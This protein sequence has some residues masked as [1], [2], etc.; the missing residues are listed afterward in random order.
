M[1]FQCAYCPRYFSSTYALKRHISNKHPITED[2]EQETIVPS[3]SISEEFE[4]NIEN[5]LDYLSNSPITSESAEED[6]MVS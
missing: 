2:L 4:S 1:S 3:L 5:F 6:Q